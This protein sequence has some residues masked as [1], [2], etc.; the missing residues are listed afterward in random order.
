MYIYIN[1]NP[2]LVIL[3]V[4]LLLEGHKKHMGMTSRITL[5]P[6]CDVDLMLSNAMMYNQL[7]YK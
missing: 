5:G 1:P 7:M 6:T 4:T 3:K 2:I